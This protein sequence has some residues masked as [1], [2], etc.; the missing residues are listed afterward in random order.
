RQELERLRG[1]GSPAA[2][3]DQRLALLAFQEGDL[4]EAQRRFADLAARGDVGEGV[5]LYLADIAARDGDAA[6][7]LAGYRQLENSS[8]ALTARTRAAAILLPDNRAAAFSP[9]RDYPGAP[10]ARP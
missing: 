8:L 5:I 3:V 2:D 7:A 10:P 1:A 4:A 9:L 6:A